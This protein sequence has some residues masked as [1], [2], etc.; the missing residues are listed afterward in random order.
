METLPGRNSIPGRGTGARGPWGNHM[1]IAALRQ[2][3]RVVDIPQN[4]FLGSIKN[5]ADQG[6]SLHHIELRWNEGDTKKLMGIDIGDLTEGWAGPPRV[7]VV[8]R[9][10]RGL[11]E[12]T[13]QN[14][15]LTPQGGQRVLD[16]LE[17][18]NHDG[19]GALPT[20]PRETANAGVGFGEQGV[21]LL[22]NSDL[23]GNIGRIPSNYN[24]DH[25]W[26]AAAEAGVAPIDNA[27]ASARALLAE[28]GNLAAPAR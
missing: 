27:I 1:T 9:G 13:F 2:T 18:L 11:A 4:G 7:D 16:L 21:A 3:A 23:V 26:A 6:D 28:P 15:S 20:L 24:V 19:L 12:P 22:F 5:A 8:S 10:D 25:G 14:F 17:G